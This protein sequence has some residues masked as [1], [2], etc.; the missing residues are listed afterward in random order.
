MNIVLFGKTLSGKS[1]VA[2][3][4]KALG[5]ILVVEYTT[6]P[7]REGE[8]DHVD[9]HFISYDE[10]VRLENEGFF[11]ESK[12]V[13]TIY[14]PWRYG[15]AKS[16]FDSDRDTVT[17][18]GPLQLKQM[19]ERGIPVF[20]VLLDADDSLIEERANLRHDDIKEVCRRLHDDNPAYDMM[21]G[22]ASL[23]VDASKDTESIVQ[24]ILTE[25]KRRD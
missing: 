1:T 9:Y 16:E 10:F 20:S 3:R 12:E 24:E 21:R 17:V 8:K 23:I 7:M 11:A 4:L 13:Y 25:I 5:Y 14:G 15:A 2:K 19:E 22:H 18:M 6:R